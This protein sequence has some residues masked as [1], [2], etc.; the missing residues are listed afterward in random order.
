MSVQQRI[1][2]LHEGI[3]ELLLSGPPLLTS[4]QNRWEGFLLEEHAAPSIFDAPCHE[5]ET[6][7][8]H[9]HTGPPALVEWI[10]A[11][12]VSRTHTQPGSASIAPKGLR[13]SMVLK[14]DAAEER[15]A[16]VLAVS[17]TCGRSNTMA[18]NSG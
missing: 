12:R 11:G 8:I 17:M 16:C 15:A 18:S 14:R 6:H 1:K 5:H 3:P 10:K 7:V 2:V 4:A 13:H 9:L